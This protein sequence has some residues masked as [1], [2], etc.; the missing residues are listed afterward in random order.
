MTAKIECT[1]C[2]SAA[3]IERLAQLERIYGTAL[4]AHSD[5][6]IQGDK[7]ISKK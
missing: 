5:T 7:R 1:K 2:P 4:H 3:Q 6:V